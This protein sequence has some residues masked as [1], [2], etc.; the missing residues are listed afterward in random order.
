MFAK[1]IPLFAPVGRVMEIP[2]PAIISTAPVTPSTDVTPF[3]DVSTG[4]PFN[5]IPP[6][7]EI[8]AV[9]V[10]CAVNGVVVAKPASLV[11]DC[12]S[13]TIWSVNVSTYRVVV[14]FVPPS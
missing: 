9:N 2:V 8:P 6:A 14:K 13:V 4:K 1:V 10:C 3:A 12:G 11:A 5:V 7:T